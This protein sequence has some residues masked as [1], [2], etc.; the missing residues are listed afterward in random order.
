MSREEKEEEISEDKFL[1]F[2]RDTKKMRVEKI[3]YKNP[4]SGNII[5]LDIYAG[6]LEGLLLAEIEFI[7]EKEAHDFVGP[8]W[9]G[10]EVTYDERYKNRN[11]A[12][13]GIPALT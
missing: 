11:L 2:W 6:N 7:S 10:K 12:V 9:L 5:E 8:G 1:T 13:N 4:F 3:R